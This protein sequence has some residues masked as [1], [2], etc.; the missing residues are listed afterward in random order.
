MEV[1]VPETR[2]Q[3]D[4][5]GGDQLPTFPLELDVQEGLFLLGVWHEEGKGDVWGWS[6]ERVLPDDTV[7]GRSLPGIYAVA[8]EMLPLGPP[9]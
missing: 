2:K 5:Q 9:E 6:L 8:E 3:P 7:G 1:H 4:A